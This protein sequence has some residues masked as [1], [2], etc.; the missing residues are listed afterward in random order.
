MYEIA[1]DSKRRNKLIKSIIKNKEEGKLLDSYDA[2]I[3]NISK[4]I[5]ENIYSLFKFQEDTNTVKRN[6][7]EKGNKNGIEEQL[8]R[9]RDKSSKLQKNSTLSDEEQKT[10]DEQARLVQNKRKLISAAEDDLSLLTAVS[11][12]T[13]FASSFTDKYPFVKL[14]IL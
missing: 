5:R 7:L 10:F 2:E 9:L 1:F 6:L 12:D 14:K 8:S 3:E 13:P 11:N 4:V